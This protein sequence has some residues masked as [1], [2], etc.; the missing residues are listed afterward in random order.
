MQNT[1]CMKKKKEKEMDAEDDEFFDAISK[2]EAVINRTELMYIKSRNV[3]QATLGY[4]VSINFGR[5]LSNHWNVCKL[6]EQ[7]LSHET[8]VKYNLKLRQKK[9]QGSYQYLLTKY[10][11]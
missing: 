3:R 4:Y 2:P 10:I 8:V 7:P 11:K 1:K 6:N 9:M 5:P